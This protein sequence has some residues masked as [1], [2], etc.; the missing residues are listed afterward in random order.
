MSTPAFYT[1]SIFDM[2]SA[3]VMI[4]ASTVDTFG[5]CPVRFDT[6]DI[7]I[8]TPPSTQFTSLTDTICADP[9]S[10]HILDLSGRIVSG[11]GTGFWSDVDMTM[12]NLSDPSSVDFSGIAPGV[13]RLSYTTQSATPPCEDSVYILTVTILD[14]GC[15]ELSLDHALVEVC[16]SGDFDLSII[17]L[18]ADQ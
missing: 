18:L 3:H 5:F 6:V 8:P 12:V 14:C 1:P 17:I 13:Y 2:A 16:N 10:N 7:F 4:I 9:D 15:P 11:D